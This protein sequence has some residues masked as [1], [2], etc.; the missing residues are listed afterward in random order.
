MAFLTTDKIQK[1][2]RQLKNTPTKNNVNI[3][4]YISDRG[5]RKSSA[6]QEMLIEEFLAGNTSP[7]II[8]RDKIN[9]SISKSWLSEYARTKYKYIQLETEKSEVFNNSMTITY[10]TDTRTDRKSILYYGMF[11][12]M[13]D[14]YKSNYFEGWNKVKYVIYEEAIPR[15]KLIQDVKYINERT[16][17]SLI[18]L[19]S[20]CSTVSRGNNITAI[21][22]GNDISYN[23]LNPIT[24]TFD[25]LERIQPDINICDNC[26]IEDRE[27]NFI[28]NYF[29]FLG[30]SEHW[31]NVNELNVS[32]KINVDNLAVDN[33]ALHSQYNVYYFYNYRGKIY[34][35]AQNKKTKQLTKID[36]AYKLGYTDFCYLTVDQYIN[37]YRYRGNDEQKQ[38]INDYLDINNNVIRQDQ[39][40]YKAYYID[41]LLSL[42]NYELTEHEQIIS[43]IKNCVEMPTI[44][45]N[46]YVKLKIHELYKTLEL[47]AKNI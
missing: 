33:I 28:F 19:L 5:G 22:L 21:L 42:K 9:R 36:I 2:I 20:I 32:N 1:D 24:I 13:A 41:E 3:L 23:L 40:K 26:I 35:S 17:Q 4:C 45:C 27:Y 37:I 6:I 30:S 44:Y 15:Q 38:I 8:I 34:V 14:I 43:L 39:P 16:L 10:I 18:D 47:Y 31:L 11:L 46:M 25:L 12:S 29:S 7:A